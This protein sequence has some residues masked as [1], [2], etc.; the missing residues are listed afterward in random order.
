MLS[1]LYISLIK[2]GRSTQTSTTVVGRNLEKHGRAS[3]S[4]SS[5]LAYLSGLWGQYA[6]NVC[7]T[8][9]ITTYITY[10]VIDQCAWAEVVFGVG[11][12]VEVEVV[13]ADGAARAGVLV[14]GMM[15]RLRLIRDQNSMVV[16]NN[17]KDGAL[18]SGQVWRVALQQVT[19]P[20]K[21]TTNAI[22]GAAV[23]VTR[24]VAMAPGD[25]NAI[26]MITAAKDIITAQHGDDGPAREVVKDLAPGQHMRAQALGPPIDDEMVQ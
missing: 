22:I 26:A 20:D 7:A 18:V 12:G 23:I 14:A 21:G 2:G 3:S 16:L 25:M 24:T 5:S 11:V 1:T 10:A 15:T 4:L 8:G 19:L 6:T 13:P 9:S 17:G